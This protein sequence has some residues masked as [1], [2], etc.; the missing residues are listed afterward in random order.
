MI[1]LASESCSLPPVVHSNDRVYIHILGVQFTTLPGLMGSQSQV[2]DRK[3][4][5]GVSGDTQ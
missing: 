1:P 2:G 3:V 5:V 4:I